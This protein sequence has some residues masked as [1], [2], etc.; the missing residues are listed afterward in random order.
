MWL[1]RYVHGGGGLV[2]MGRNRIVLIG[3]SVLFQS[4][5]CVCVCVRMSHTR[6]PHAGQT[7]CDNKLAKTIFNGFYF[8]CT[9]DAQLR[10]C[11]LLAHRVRQHDECSILFRIVWRTFFCL[12]PI[13]LTLEIRTELVV[14][15][16]NMTT[17][18]DDK[19]E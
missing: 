6:A 1:G 18:D 14:V 19:Y 8:E 15:I 2:V 13:G 11:V 5:V 7:R 4:V 10:L 12:L 17:L 3:F 9:A 16:E